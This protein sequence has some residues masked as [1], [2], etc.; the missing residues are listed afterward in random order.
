MTPEDFQTLI[1]NPESAI[2]DF[3]RE[4]Y[5]LKDGRHKLTKDIVAM[6]NTPR[7]QP[8]HIVL[9]VDWTPE[10]GSIVVGLNGQVDDAEVQKAFHHRV[11]PRP[12]FVYY[13]LRFEDKQVGI[14]E[15]GVS[16][17]GPYMAADQIEGMAIGAVYYRQ[18]STNG[19]AIGPQ[20]RRIVSW[21]DDNPPSN[22]PAEQV[23][24]DHRPFEWSKFL[25]D[26]HDLDHS[27]ALLLAVD[28]VPT[29]AASNVDALGQIPWSVVFDFDPKSD[30]D[31]LLHQIEGQLAQHRL[32]HRATKGAHQVHPD[33]GTH[34]FFA[35]GAAGLKETLVPNKGH[36]QWVKAYKKEL[37]TQIDQAAHT[38][39]PSAI[40]LIAI[41]SDQALYRYLQ[42]LL[43]EI[44]ATF[45]DAVTSVLVSNNIEYRRIAEELDVRYCEMSLRSLCN[46]IS[47][48]YSEASS[49][50]NSHRTLPSS[51]GA[52]VTIPRRDELWFK[53]NLD[54]MYKG[55]GLDGDDDEHA[56]R[57]GA[58]I[59]W[60]N[61]HLHH[62]CARDV[63]TAIIAQT[64]NDLKS[65]SAVRIHIYHH[66]GSG[67]SSVALRV[68]WD[69]HDRFPVVILRL[70]AAAE[71]I[72]SRLR[73]I[74]SLTESSVLAIVD[75]SVYTESLVDDLY[76]SI[77]ARQIPVVIIHV[78]RRFEE[79]RVARR[80]YWIPS[81]LTDVEA[82][83]FRVVYSKS[84]RAR[85]HR[86]NLLVGHERTA[87][88]F[89]LTAFGENFRG[90]HRHVADRSINLT[91][92]QRQIL[93]FIAIAHY[94]GQQSIHVQALAA[95]LGFP[96]DRTLRLERLFGEESRHALELLAT[97]KRN[98]V[99]ATHQL[100][101][102]EI[103]QQ[104]GAVDGGGSWKEQ[105]SKWGKDF[106][107]FCAADD[108][109]RRYSLLE[110]VQRVFIFR[111]N[112]EMLGTDGATQAQS[113]RFLADIP[114]QHGRI[115]MLQH[116]T[117]SFP[118]EAHFHA[119]LG[120]AL[121]LAGEFKNAV[122]SIDTALTL[123]PTDYVIHHM[124]GMI[125]RNWMRSVHIEDQSIDELVSMSKEAAASFEESREHQSDAEYA[126]IS[127]VQMLLDLVDRAS[128]IY[129]GLKYVLSN[130]DVDPF[131]RSSLE[132]AENLLDQ[133]SSLFVGESPSTYVLNCRAKIQHLYGHFP[134]ALQTLDSL[135]SRPHIDRKPI[136]RQ[137]VWTLLR[138]KRG[139]WD[140]LSPRGISRARRLLQENL[141]EDPHDA[142][143]LRLWLRV[144]RHDSVI[145]TLNGVIE[146]VS[147]WRSN[148]SSLDALYYLYVLHMLNGIQ[149]S[150]QG[151]PEGEVVLNECRS[152]ARLRRDRRRSF[153]W[154]G[155]GE[156]V[157]ALVHQSQLGDWSEDFWTKADQLRRLDGRISSIAAPQEGYIDLSCGL[158][159]FFVPARSQIF[160]GR[161]ENIPVTLNLGFSYDGPRA[162]NVEATDSE[163]LGENS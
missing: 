160:K 25:S 76:D 22:S 27:H 112:R 15:I 122:A 85:A 159:A 115:D 50:I 29:G 120:R 67:G 65:T 35:R 72:A 141:E 144:I 71:D 9:G 81:Q 110:V 116:L 152:V 21:F 82:D 154:V 20:H 3:K 24:A 134:A 137:I 83:R 42:T 98:K 147:Y 53:E 135:L 1:G 107:D 156:G 119:H 84:V 79:Q 8:A 93:V 55:L 74:A 145:P 75:S 54:V 127:E 140:E 57:M 16:A 48:H 125:Y 136:R 96:S 92:V 73:H 34:W 114:S 63:T 117:K 139:R 153:E 44:Y 66:P 86:L 158:R 87:F 88:F 161:D 62:D 131:L 150:N 31:G 52:P 45:G 46:G 14:I 2:L 32:I 56:Y 124:R 97:D 109:P 12:T 26:T 100:V 77:R 47:T 28:R 60:R 90:L 113:S 132:R 128:R 102:Q 37:S 151:V 19:P 123:V 58:D 149:G 126:Y 33:P 23:P 89:G 40:T 142:T 4:V 30:Q 78:L 36:P 148:S 51:S 103:M 133:V 49:S 43:D 146:R 17:T 106:A 10:D 157:G 70:T 111:D 105:L 7:E 162:W 99:R 61:L 6:A 155:L 121:G 91:P 95:L 13:P 108:G 118:E 64:E 68:A 39:G 101:A 94:Y 104:N 129:G 163:R 80:R 138:S 143:S 11:E 41:W 69:I 59:S 130:R 38:I 18:G 5:D